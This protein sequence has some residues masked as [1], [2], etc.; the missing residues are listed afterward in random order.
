MSSIAAS[1][2]PAYIMKKRQEEKLRKRVTVEK[3]SAELDGE[4]DADEKG[5]GDHNSSKT[6]LNPKNRN[7]KIHPAGNSPAHHRL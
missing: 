3:G 2:A 1:Y 5:H 4:N 7:K 6:M